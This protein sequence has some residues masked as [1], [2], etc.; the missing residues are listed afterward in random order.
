MPFPVPGFC[1]A[2]TDWHVQCVWEGWMLCGWTRCLLSRN[3]QVPGLTG[4]ELDWKWYV[5]IPCI[6]R[7]LQELASFCS[8]YC[9]PAPPCWILRGCPDRATPGLLRPQ[10][11]AG[12]AQLGAQ[13][14]GREG[15]VRSQPLQG[16]SLPLGLAQ[17]LLGLVLHGYPPGWALPWGFPALVNYSFIRY[18]SSL[19]LLP[20]LTGIPL[21]TLVLLN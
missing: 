13:P 14:V 7:A 2:N 18:F 20:C 4:S 6:P 3:P 10:A 16:S 17:P 11:S 19:P 1:S 15:S 9:S 5:T 21:M 12:F 8:P